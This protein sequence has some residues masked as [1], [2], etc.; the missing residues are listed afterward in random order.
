VT[1]GAL[2]STH[3]FLSV[4]RYFLADALG[5]LSAASGKREEA[6]V[7]FAERVGDR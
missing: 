4:T 5:K 6:R 2:A 3:G 7:S 1:L